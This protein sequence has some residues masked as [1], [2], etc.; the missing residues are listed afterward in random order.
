MGA[1]FVEG[2][3][4]VRIPAGDDCGLTGGRQAFLLGTVNRPP[5]SK[6]DADA[7]NGFGSLS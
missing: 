3:V 5:L 4:P 6:V 7:A 2:R 1:G